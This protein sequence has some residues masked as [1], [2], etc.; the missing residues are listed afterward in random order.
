MRLSMCGNTAAYIA[1]YSRALDGE[2]LTPL[3]SSEISYL[4][5][6]SHCLIGRWVGRQ[7]TTQSRGAAG[8]SASLF[9]GRRIPR[10]ILK[11]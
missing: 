9:E 8:D 11:G 7:I 3:S 5:M 10:I 6:L 1:A 4:V 2:I